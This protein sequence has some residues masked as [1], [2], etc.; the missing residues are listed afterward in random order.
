M[1]AKN[2]TVSNTALN[3]INSQLSALSSAIAGMKKGAKAALPS[4]PS[5]PHEREPGLKEAY[6]D[7]RDTYLANYIYGLYHPDVVFKEHLDIRFPATMPIPTTTFSFKDTFTI[8]PNGSGN[9]VLWWQPNFLGSDL[10]LLR[11]LNLNNPEAYAGV[12]SNLYYNDS[13][14]VD[15]NS[16][17]DS[18]W[19]CRVFKHVQQTFSKYRLTSACIKVRYTGK[20]L[21]QS[22]CFAACATYSTFP[23]TVCAVPTTDPVPAEYDYTGTAYNGGLLDKWG[24]FDTIRQGQW[25]HTTNIVSDPDGITCVYLPSDP[26]SEAFVNNGQTIDEQYHQVAYHG[27]QVHGIWQPKNANL[28]YAICGYGID[29]VASVVTVECYYNF[30]IIVREEQMP[31]FRP[32][33]VDARL[34]RF[35]SRLN[36]SVR[37]IA[38]KFGGVTR[39]KDHEAPSTMARIQSALGNAWRYAGDIVPLLLKVGKYVL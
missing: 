23:R 17:A 25:A 32:S 38:G 3:K 11:P 29:S 5:H 34:V 26:L 36:D 14:V 28:G 6:A 15:G 8:A 1:S 33:V 35:G 18:G 31:Y 27:T 13:I 24:D 30:E 7:Y 21:D 37:S 10:E 4:K 19:K 22:G 9:F 20:V 16:P 12:F 2:A 39:S